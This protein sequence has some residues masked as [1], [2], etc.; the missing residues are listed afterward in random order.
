MPHASNRVTL[1]YMD[2]IFHR[3]LR[4]N[5]GEILR[6]AEAGELIQITNNGRVVA[7]IGP[8][9]E[10]VLDELISRGQA[11]RAV[12]PLS[13]RPPRERRTAVLPRS[14]PTLA[15]AGER[16]LPRRFGGDEA[17]RGRAGI[18]RSIRGDQE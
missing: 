16:H 13:S 12:K 8:P 2:K 18:D 4:N 15:A 3:E 11:R 1:S 7:T 9:V 14:S 10:S 6:R 5:S 17:D